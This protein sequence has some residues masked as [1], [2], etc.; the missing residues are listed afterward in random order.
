MVRVIGSSIICFVVLLGVSGSEVR[1]AT[2]Q[3]N[4]HTEFQ[5]HAGSTATIE[6]EGLAAEGSLRWYGT[7]AG[8]NLNGVNFTGYWTRNGVPGNYLY[9]IDDDYVVDGYRQYDFNSGAVLL[10]P[11]S[12]SPYDGWMRVD[13]P[14]GVTAVAGDLGGDLQFG[15]DVILSTGDSFLIEGPPRPDTA[16][17]GFASDHPIDWMIIRGTDFTPW[18]CCA[19]L[20]NF[21]FGT[22]QV[23]EPSSLALLALGLACL[24]VWRRRAGDNGFGVTNPA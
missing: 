11:D 17:F 16:F 20:D 14:A 8:L 21:T 6:F 23:P 24:V 12:R 18:S 4:S 13:L 1:A 10:I 22:A 3:F 2:V 5:A 19:K 9:V 7:P 15:Y